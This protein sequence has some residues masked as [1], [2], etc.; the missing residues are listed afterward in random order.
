MS[1]GEDLRA[2]RE[3]AGLSI[4]GLAE[5]AG[6]AA[7]T[8]W[9][10]EAGRLDPT[11]TMV[12]KLRAATSET[13]GTDEVTREEAVS[14]ALGRLTASELLRDPDRLLGRARRRVAAMRRRPELTRGGRQVLTEW[15]RLLAG[16][17]EDV[18]AALIDPS[19][20]GYELRAMIPFT[21]VINDETRLRVVRRAS[22]E[23][24]ATRSA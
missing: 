16:P 4:R 2:T 12:A 7:S 8:V 11:T 24:R 5:R 19:P 14:L 18:V 3:R 9:R 23:H 22:R 6:I 13:R 15:D 10:I 20:R 17:L 21:G 1:V